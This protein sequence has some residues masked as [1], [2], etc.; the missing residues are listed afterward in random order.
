MVGLA[1]NHGGV[2]DDPLV[3]FAFLISYYCK[4]NTSF[5]QTII[6]LYL[7]AFQIA[8]KKIFRLAHQALKLQL[9]GTLVG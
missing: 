3:L 6:S 7:T 9:H 4:K 2:D 8:L 1:R 5:S